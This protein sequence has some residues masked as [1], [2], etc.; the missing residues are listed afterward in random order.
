MHTSAGRAVRVNGLTQSKE[1]VDESASG[2][3]S[4]HVIVGWV[5]ERKLLAV[6]VSGGMA[7][8]RSGIASWFESHGM[9]VRILYTKESQP[10]KKELKF[11]G[12]RAI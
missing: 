10:R 5:V 9:I 2:A 11:L 7:V 6:D 8:L 3:S 4:E 12:P 1:S